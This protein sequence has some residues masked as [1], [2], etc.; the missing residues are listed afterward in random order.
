MM[1]G[2]LLMRFKRLPVGIDI[3]TSSIKVV[4]LGYGSKG[5]I[6]KYAGLTELLHPE[7]ESGDRG[8]VMAIYD[9][10][11]EG[12]L[13]KNMAAI[14]FSKKNPII[15]YL[16]LPKMP[17]EELKEAMR[18]ETK[19]I[20]AIPVEDLIIDFLIVGEIGE[21][22]IKR[23]EVVLVA[24]ER[25][26]ILDQISG[27]KQTGLRIAA[28]DV[29]PLSLLNTVRL[30]YAADL[31]NNIVFIDIGAGKTEINISKNGILRFTRSVQIGGDEITA[32]IMRE[33]QVE[34]ADAERMKKEFGMIEERSP[35]PEKPDIRLKEIIKGEVDRLIL[36]VQRSIDYYRAQFREGSIKKIILIGG[37]PLMPGFK[38]YFASYF[39]VEV[40]IDD[41]FSMIRCD[42]PSFSELQLMAPRFSSSVGLALRGRGA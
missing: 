12:R 30:N 8:V 15:R 22:D 18:W 34:Y 17:K 27:L 35:D 10:L 14:N 9:I 40:A 1:L 26:A 24:V 31:T 32:A 39:E 36:E 21:R 28:I 13:K 7:N 19:K 41:P 23:Y 3:G 42:D 5:I 33:L 6:L 29:N 37:T 2:D 4:Q 38:E 11:R 20:T 16:T 25:A